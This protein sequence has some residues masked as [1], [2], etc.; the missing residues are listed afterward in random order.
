MEVGVDCH[1]RAGIPEGLLVG[2]LQALS[3]QQAKSLLDLMTTQGQLKVQATYESSSAALPAIFG[4]T[5]SSETQVSRLHLPRWLL[6]HHVLYFLTA[7][8]MTD[9]LEIG[10]GLWLFMLLD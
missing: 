10:L 4:L 7:F 2:Q 3:P 9:S 5:A 8:S 1:H 6:K